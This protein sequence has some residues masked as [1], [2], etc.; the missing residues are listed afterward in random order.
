MEEHRGY[1]EPDQIQGRADATNFLD[2]DYHASDDE[3]NSKFTDLATE[4]HPDQDGTTD[5][6]KAL[7]KSLEIVTETDPDTATQRP[8]GTT[9]GTSQYGEWREAAGGSYNV[10]QRFDEEDVEKVEAEVEKKLRQQDPK[11]DIVQEFGVEQVAEVL[12]FLILR[13]ATELG[14]LEK[15]L[16]QDGIFEGNAEAATGGTYSNKGR[17]TGP[18]GGKRGGSGTYSARRRQYAWGGPSP[19]S[20]EPE[21]EDDEE[22][23][24]GEDEGGPADD[25][26]F[27]FGDL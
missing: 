8:G 7:K 19:G 17:R 25:V 24:D 9:T 21:D 2:I 16:S 5:L 3:A 18:W 6:F 1:E 26:D 23:E 4:L 20:E 10:T 15:M 14:D 22:E 11:P 12:T 13:G 27:D